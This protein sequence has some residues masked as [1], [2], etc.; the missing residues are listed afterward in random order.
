VGSIAGFAAGSQG[1]IWSQGGWLLLAALDGAAV[2]LVLVVW[3]V[4]MVAPR[5]VYSHAN[6]TAKTIRKGIS[7]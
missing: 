1:V 7:R 5:S 6:D 3:V 4:A 2:G